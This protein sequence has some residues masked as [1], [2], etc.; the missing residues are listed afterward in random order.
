MLDALSI[1]VYVCET[2]HF[3]DEP[4]K[5]DTTPTKPNTV[6]KEAV[7]GWHPG[8]LSTVESK[9]VKQTWLKNS[10]LD[11]GFKT[12]GVEIKK[13]IKD[14]TSIGQR[15]R[16]R[17]A[18]AMEC[19]GKHVSIATHNVDQDYWTITK[20]PTRKY[21]GLIYKKR[22]L[23]VE[24]ENLF[25]HNKKTASLRPNVSDTSNETMRVHRGRVE[26][27]LSRNLDISDIAVD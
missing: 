20:S 2:M 6:P 15:L 16:A 9:K 13:E 5:P 19:L 7:S 10:E 17:V 1:V 12:I 4:T 24:T 18:A 27:K 3:S 14:E 11:H 21:A 23:V 25:L 22:L 8:V 26:I